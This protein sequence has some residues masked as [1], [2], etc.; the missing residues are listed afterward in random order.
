[1]ILWVVGLAHA[2]GDEPSVEGVGI[3]IYGEA[4][5][6][7]LQTG[8]DNPYV[9][10]VTLRRL[11]LE[12]EKEIGSFEALAELEWE[13]AI[14]CDGCGGAVEVEQGLVTWNKSE[15]FAL[16]AGLM[17]VPF[18]MVNLEHEPGQFLGVQRPSTDQFIVPT[19]W[20]EIGV[21]VR[22]PEGGARI[23][24]ALLAPPDPTRIGSTGLA[25]SS[26]LGSHARLNS[27]AAAAR[28][29]VQPIGANV[30]GLNVYATNAGPNGDFYDAGGERLH[31]FLPLIGGAIDLHL[32]KGAFDLRG[33]AVAFFFPEAGTL[34]AAHREDGSPWFGDDPS[35]VIPTRWQGA[36]L[37]G[38]IDFLALGGEHDQRLLGFVRPEVYDNTAAVPAGKERDPAKNVTE[39]TFGTEWWPVPQ[40]GVKGDVM[41]RDRELGL[42]ERQIDLGLAWIF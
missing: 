25:P 27:V 21:G 12:V 26:S 38:A 40:V 7:W 18:G 31:L 15:R 17:L 33:E 30:L 13:N 1:V 42:D 36:Y 16:D 23:H 37:Q 11:T 20:R 41:L 35:D 22:T 29:E 2:H 39:W 4:N 28:F 5:A 24:A 8:A 14:A 19:T 3:E 10:D 9:G 32:H 6:Q 34:M